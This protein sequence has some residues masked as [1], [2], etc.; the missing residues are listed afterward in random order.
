MYISRSDTIRYK[1][2]RRGKSCLSVS[3]ACSTQV[4][5][6]FEYTYRTP[7]CDTIR[8][9][10][11]LAFISSTHLSEAASFTCPRLSAPPFPRCSNC[12]RTSIVDYVRS[13]TSDT[14]FDLCLQCA[15]DVRNYK[16]AGEGFQMPQETLLPL[17]A[18]V[19][20]DRSL[21]VS[22]DVKSSDA[23]E[24]TRGRAKV[25]AD[26][27]L[28]LPSA[29]RK[30]D[31]LQNSDV[32][33]MELGQGF[34]G[35]SEGQT[36]S[37]GGCPKAEQGEG[38]CRKGGEVEG[39][40]PK[41]AGDCPKDEG[42]KDERPKADGR[43]GERPE[44][45][46]GQAECPK[47][48]GR[49]GPAVRL[50]ETGPDKG[51]IPSG[52]VAEAETGVAEEIKPADAPSSEEAK[53]TEGAVPKEGLAV[54]LHG[55]V[56]DRVTGAAANADGGTAGIQLE[57]KGGERQSLEGSA[58]VT[59][60]AP[61]VVSET[62]G[63]EGPGTEMN[64]NG[65]AELQGKE[66]KLRLEVTAALLVEDRGPA[67]APLEK[68]SVEEREAVPEGGA[69]LPENSGVTKPVAPL[70]LVT[71]TLK[72]KPGV[73][74]ET[75]LPRRQG[76]SGNLRELVAL[77]D[78]ASHGNQG[79][80]SERPKRGR[81][82]DNALDTNPTS[83]STS[84]RTRPLRSGSRR[85]VP[86]EQPA[87]VV[88]EDSEEE[89][90]VR[91]EGDLPP[92]APLPGGKIGCPGK[93]WGGCGKGVLELRTI[94]GHKWMEHLDRGQRKIVGGGE[95]KPQVRLVC[96]GSLIMSKVWVW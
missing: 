76:R 55:T 79:M 33:K 63:K 82:C 53:F 42:G 71:E 83:P 74:K 46:G 4:S 38:E 20:M 91:A 94:Q 11:F 13:C 3:Q 28:A 75:G 88:L 84:G 44:C 2:N 96:M 78:K 85:S 60:D 10:E 12:C 68:G 67:P 48:E 87:L 86:K 22:G 29:A 24:K 95:G 69:R 81:P 17:E 25:Q 56:G 15:Q 49:D 14:H 89:A 36:V 45:E 40:G 21:V 18:P 9:S 43:K 35:S 70:G 54:F 72:A 92:W 37:E 59:V 27:V 93:E 41:A 57:G 62:G 52:N 47:G 32:L 64:E 30:D 51:L 73:A 1:L 19:S 34:D 16:M 31:P 90:E 77:A 65:V 23:L 7:L 39:E 5:P 8:V 80:G 58:A 26:A 50:Q 66:G 6:L 61:G